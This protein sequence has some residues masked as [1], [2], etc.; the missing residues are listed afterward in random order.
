MLVVSIALMYRD[1]EFCCPP[2]INLTLCVCVCQLYL[3]IFLKERI[4]E[5]AQSI[6]IIK[7]RLEVKNRDR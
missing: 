3:N 1:T 5:Y 2:E 7:K 6:G 4:K